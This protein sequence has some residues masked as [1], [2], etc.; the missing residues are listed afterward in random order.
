MIT[1]TDWSAV[2]QRYMMMQL[3]ALQIEYSWLT[4]DY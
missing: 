4:I 3:L 1:L 2:Y